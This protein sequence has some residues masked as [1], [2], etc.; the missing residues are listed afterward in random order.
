MDDAWE[1]N[2]CHTVSQLD[3]G[4]W[5]RIFR[6]EIRLPQSPGDNRN[7]LHIGADEMYAVP[8][9]D[10]TRAAFC[11]GISLNDPQSFQTMNCITGV[12][13]TMTQ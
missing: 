12:G 4:D 3:S 13:G 9:G 5:T 2:A 10:M 11:Y 1:P 6:P 8:P 7:V